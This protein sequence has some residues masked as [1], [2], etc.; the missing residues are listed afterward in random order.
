MAP[1]S[2]PAR[3]AAR[4]KASSCLGL[5][6][7]ANAAVAAVAAPTLQSPDHGAYTGAYI[8]FGE[9]EDHVTREAIDAF[10]Q[11]VGKHQA[12]VA[13]SSYW[14][15]GDFPAENLRVID[16][17]GA[18]PLVYWSPWGA[19]Y[20]QGRKIKPDAFSLS[21][22][23]AGDC[24]PYIDR[25]AAGA[26]AFG[27]PLL[28]SFA[29]EPNSDW[30]PWCGKANG[31]D[32]PAPDGRGF[33]GPELYKRAWRR[34]VDR[35]RAAGA[36]NVSWVFQANSDSHPN[37]PWNAMAQYYPGADCADWLGMSAYG[38]LTPGEDDWSDWKEVMNKAYN[39]LCALDPAKP[40]MLAEWGC[41]EFPESG[42]K[43]GWLRD[44]FDAMNRGKYPRLKAAVFW[45][46]RWQNKDESY[47][48]LR[49]QSSPGALKAY[50]QGVADAFW[51]DRPA[52]SP[53]P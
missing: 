51:L 13:S 52:F 20:E 25:W 29:C 5:L 27:K 18:A 40:V 23:V 33:A 9:T 41:G 4:R 53:P 22:I 11:L 31:A 37:K 45:H 30:F 32:A 14:G 12:I 43:A 38:Q 26:K 24:D 28:V 48:N 15:R 2:P 16:A 6:A 3:P 42:D 39:R 21:H 36:S 1:T 50:R 19:P 17:Y 44:A 34:I 8:D 35:V 10:E 47:S 49:V 7:L 46:E